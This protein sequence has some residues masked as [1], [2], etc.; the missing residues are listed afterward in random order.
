MKLT[1]FGTVSEDEQ[2]KIL[3]GGFY[4][5]PEGKPIYSE[6]HL[7]DCCLDLVI[8]RLLKVK[9]TRIDAKRLAFLERTPIEAMYR[10]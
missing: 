1:K 5:N 7:L 9:Q 10:A 2:G 4:I 6:D 3:L 8:E